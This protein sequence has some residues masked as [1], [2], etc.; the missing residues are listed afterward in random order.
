MID[1]ALY[2]YIL[3]INMLESRAANYLLSVV[4]IYIKVLAAAFLVA[5]LYFSF[6]KHNY[7]GL[8]RLHHYIIL[9]VCDDK[10]R[11]IVITTTAL[12]LSPAG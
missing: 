6:T 4:S 7:G 9:D 8:L 3:K 12:L 5:R 2:Y 11:C 10:R 1:V